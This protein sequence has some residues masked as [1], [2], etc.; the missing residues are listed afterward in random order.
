MNKEF[1]AWDKAPQK[2]SYPS[3]SSWIYEHE[4][5]ECNINEEKHIV[6]GATNLGRFHTLCQNSQR[7]MEET[8]GFHPGKNMLVIYEKHNKEIINIRN[9]I[10]K[11]KTCS[12]HLDK[13]LALTYICTIS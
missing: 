11:R 2:M 4:S 9:Y 6:M 8:K 7:F 12:P 3:N 10:K 1:R 5:Q 13:P